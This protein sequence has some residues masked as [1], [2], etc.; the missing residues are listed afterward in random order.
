[1]RVRL[2][3]RTGLKVSELCLGTMTFGSVAGVR[4]APGCDEKE[5]LAILGAYRYENDRATIRMVGRQGMRRSGTGKEAV[6]VRCIGHGFGRAGARPSSGNSC[7][8]QY[9]RP[10]HRMLDPTRVPT[11]PPVPTALSTREGRSSDRPLL[12]QIQLRVVRRGHRDLLPRPG[13]RGGEGDG[14]VV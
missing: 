7:A 12:Q 8:R 9:S 13:K 3:G 4:G 6:I 5:S 1:M 10:W 14:R 2:M 11:F